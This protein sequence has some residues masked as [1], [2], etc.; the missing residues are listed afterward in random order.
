MAG[1]DW[2]LAPPV[3]SGTVL[4]GGGGTLEATLRAGGG[5]AWVVDE[6]WIEAGIGDWN[7]WFPFDAA[8]WSFPL[9]A[10]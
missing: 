10:S 6:R 1:S 4:K 3:A 8:C 9:F 7:N 5:E 2:L